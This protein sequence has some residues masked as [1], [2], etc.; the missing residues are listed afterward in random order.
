MK[1]TLALLIAAS[2]LAVPG[3]AAAGGPKPPR[4]LCLDWGSSVMLL[5]IRA[6]ARLISAE[7]PLWFYDVEGVVVVEDAYL[8]PIPVS[9]SGHLDGNRFHFAVIGGAAG[10]LTYIEF[11]SQHWEGAWD[12]VARSGVG[13]TQSV[14]ITHGFLEAIQVD[15]GP[16]DCADYPPG[17]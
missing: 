7:G 4:E 5:S 16:V 9:G 14:S 15:L 13:S 3:A 8:E 1:T 2:L 11:T 12:V 6:G 10:G 17:D